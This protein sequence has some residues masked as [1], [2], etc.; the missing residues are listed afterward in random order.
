MGVFG[1]N[2]VEPFL[3][4]PGQRKPKAVAQPIFLFSFHLQK[5]AFDAA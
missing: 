4:N 5:Q 2:Y 1:I 3:G